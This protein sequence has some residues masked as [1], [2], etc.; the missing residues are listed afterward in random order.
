MIPCGALKQKPQDLTRSEWE[1]LI[2]ERIIGRNSFRDRQIVKENLLDGRTYEWI[3]ETHLLSVR[4]VGR[5]LQDRKK[6]IYK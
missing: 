4:Q 1:R 5:I 2:D 6:Q 3:A